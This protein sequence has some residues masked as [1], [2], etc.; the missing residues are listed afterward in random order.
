MEVPLCVCVCVC[1]SISIYTQ[2]N[3]AFKEVYISYTCV[4]TDSYPLRR[5]GELRNSKRSTRFD[6]DRMVEETQVK[7]QCKCDGDDKEM[8]AVLI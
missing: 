4:Q 5:L 7:C 1:V 6:D 3:I 8:E 2:C